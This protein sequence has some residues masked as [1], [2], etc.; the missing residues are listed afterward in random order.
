MNDIILSTQNG[1]PVASS[2]DVAKR[3]GKRHDHVIRDIAEIVKSFPKNGDT[4]LFFK[5]EYVHPQNHQK[6]PMYLMNRDGFSL[7][8]MGFTGKEAAQWTAAT[9]AGQ[10][11]AGTNASLTGWHTSAKRRRTKAMRRPR[12]PYLKLARL[13]EDEGF[14]HREFAKLVGMGESTLS[15]RLNPKPEQ[16]NNEWRHY[17]ITAICRELHIPQEQIGEYFFPTVEKGA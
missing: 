7:L 13:I 1:E 8:A 16:K 15:T 3:F 5:T 11:S 17:E 12:S 9:S 14:E 4:P 2:R 10:N 6:Y